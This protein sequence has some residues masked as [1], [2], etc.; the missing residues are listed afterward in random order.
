MVGWKHHRSMQPV[1]KE[2]HKRRQDARKAMDISEF[3]P[4]DIL[5]G[6]L[7]EGFTDGLDVPTGEDAPETY[8]FDLDIPT[9][10]KEDGF[11]IRTLPDR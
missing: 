7:D 11:D 8:T 6:R 1:S 4:E 3:G 2:Y 10:E 9:F 5:E